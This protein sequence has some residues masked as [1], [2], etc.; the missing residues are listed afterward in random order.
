MCPF[1]CDCEISLL[2]LWQQQN[3]FELTLFNI[4]MSVSTHISKKNFS[5]KIKIFSFIRMLSFSRKLKNEIRNSKSVFMSCQWVAGVSV[6]W[7]M[8]VFPTFTH[9]SFPNYCW[10]VHL[11]IICMLDHW[12]GIYK[13][14]FEF[15][16]L[17]FK[18]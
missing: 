5:L 2:L 7:R 6:L 18:G 16:F 13:T 3:C 12:T 10:N 4:L 8:T 14:I 1:G 11:S 15:T 9:K 17:G